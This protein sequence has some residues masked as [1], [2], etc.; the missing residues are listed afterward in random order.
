MYFQEFLFSKD[1]NVYIFQEKKIFLFPRMIISYIIPGKDK[2]SCMYYQ[3]TEFSKFLDKEWHAG[4]IIWWKKVNIFYLL[5]CFIC[6]WRTLF[7][8]ELRKFCFLDVHTRNFI[9]SWNN[10]RFYYPR[11]RKFFFSWNIK[12]LL[13]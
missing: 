8:Q 3:E 1:D 10:I 7:I 11:T 5:W 13:S 12:I 6:M 2:I 9:F 4:S